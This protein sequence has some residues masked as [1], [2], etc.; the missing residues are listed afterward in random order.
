MAEFIIESDCVETLL[1]N[2]IQEL[3]RCRDCYYGTCHT[4]SKDG[5]IFRVACAKMFMENPEG[6]EWH[7][8]DWFCADGRKK[9]DT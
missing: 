1:E 2:G 6:N 4:K 7:T 5:G 9:D 3:V 8:P